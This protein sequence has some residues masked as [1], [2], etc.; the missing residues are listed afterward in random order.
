MKVVFTNGCFDVLHAGHVQFLRRARALGDALVVGINTDAS[1][2]A[3]KGSNRPINP[4]PDR[5]AVL[6]SIR[7]VDMV[8]QFGD[9][10]PVE[11]VKVIRP[12]VLVKGPG[13]SRENM[14]EATVASEWNAEVVIFDGPEVSST[15]I[16][17]KIKRNG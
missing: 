13:Y 14:P 17:E 1:V 9:S 8:I 4:L 5:V 10:T 2:A 11:L 12:D 16:I 3:L 6:E 7:W 15:D